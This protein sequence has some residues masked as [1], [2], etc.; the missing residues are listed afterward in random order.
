M[1]SKVA[2]KMLHFAHTVLTLNH[3][4][5]FEKHHWLGLLVTRDVTIRNDN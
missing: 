5:L 4:E 1:C 2:S 3:Q